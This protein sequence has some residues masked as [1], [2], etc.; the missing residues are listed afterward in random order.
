M[1]HDP[2][3]PPTAVWLNR[4]AWAPVPLFVVALGV[5]WLADLQTE[6]ESPILL[7]GLNFVFSTL[8]SLLVVSLLG[9]SFLARSSPG[10]LLIGCGILVWG[11]AG[12]LVPVL[13]PHG[14]NAL[15]SG[16]NSLV[17]FAAILNLVG[18]LL[19]LRRRLTPSA[20]AGSG[21][22][23][24]ANALSR[25]TLALAY[26]AAAGLVGLVTLL[27]VKGWMPVFFVQGQGGTPIRSFALGSAI[28]MLVVTAAALWLAN[29]PAPSAFARWYGAALLLVATG[30]FGIMIE[31]VHGG[32]L[33]WTGRAAQF[34]G[35][36]YMLVAALASVRESGVWE[37]SLSAAL[38]EARLAAEERQR[39]LDALL[40]FIPEGITIAS[41]PDVR[42]VRTSRYGDRLLTRGWATPTGL[43]LDDWLAKVEHYLADG[44]TPAK[45]HDLPLWKAAKLGQT[46]EGQELVLRRPN[47][48]LISVLCNAGPIKDQDGHIAGAVVAWRDVTAMRRAEEALRASEERYRRLFDTMTEGSALHEIVT[49]A[50]GRP[51]DYRFIEVNAAFERLTGLKRDDLIGKRVLEVLPG[52]EPSWIENYGRVALTGEPLHIENHAAAL[53][54]WYEVFAYRTAPR[55]FAVVFSDITI[56][57]QS[58]MALDGSRRAALNLME[59]AITARKQ[60]EQAGAELARRVEELRAANADLARFNRAAVDREL[61]MVQLKKQVNELC[62]K[63]GL[64]RKYKFEFEKHA[65]AAPVDSAGA[66]SRAAP[67]PEAQAANDQ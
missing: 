61:R 45:L 62:E 49:D 38:R 58:E 46:V 17:W 37:V 7:T 15:I 43:S 13:F 30:L 57:K 34:L 44:T 6:Y 32:A 55:Q 36:A 19:A 14:M 3:T 1:T 9:R 23:P 26:A 63:A 12:T 5:L 67:T 66:V 4:L 48:E 28:A 11:A 56:R 42:I 33:S 53:N 21:S 29:R 47:G 25:L 39:T 8:A 52:T 50:Q 64:P 31:S 24:G 60:A 2:K 27:A 22:A 35:G 65:G 16:H 51:C 18:A 54:R 20:G 41:A 10:L 40:D 59:D